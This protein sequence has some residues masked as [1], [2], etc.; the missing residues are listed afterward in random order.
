MS[1]DKDKTRYIKELENRLFKLGAMEEPP[2]FVCGYNGP[3]YYQPQTHKCASRHH[4]L[5]NY[6][7]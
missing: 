4:R 7:N 2:C 1:K 3:E 5:R 6:N